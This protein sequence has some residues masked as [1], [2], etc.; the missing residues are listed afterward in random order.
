MR[1]AVRIRGGGEE[2]SP[3][4]PAEFVVVVDAAA[5]VAADMREERDGRLKE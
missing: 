5:E 3:W 1:D 4:G 2:T